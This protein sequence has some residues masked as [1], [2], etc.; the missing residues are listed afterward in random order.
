MGK[1]NKYTPDT[2]KNIPDH[3]LGEELLESQKEN[4]ASANPDVALILTEITHRFAQLREALKNA[5]P[6][7][8]SSS[9]HNGEGEE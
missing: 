8:N 4:I 3:K 1:Q 6:I 5:R 9:T 2:V 7:S